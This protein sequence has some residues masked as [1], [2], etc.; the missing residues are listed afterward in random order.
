[1]YEA[2]DIFQRS[3]NSEI[4][5]VISAISFDTLA[6]LM[7]TS[8]PLPETTKKLKEIASITTVGIANKTVIYHALNAGWNDIE[9]AIQHYCAIENGCNAII[10]RNEKDFKKS[11]LAVFS[12]GAFLDTVDS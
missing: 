5:A 1:M 3:E 11:E 12:P 6:Y 7:Q 10:T 8:F 2:A 9:D 4:E